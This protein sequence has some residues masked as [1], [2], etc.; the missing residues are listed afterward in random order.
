MG[1]IPN[2]EQPISSEHRR[3][4]HLTERVSKK[5]TTSYVVRSGYW[6]VGPRIAAPSELIMSRWHVALLVLS[7]HIRNIILVFSFNATA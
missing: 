7:D 2:S 4:R 1:D 5:T 6:A 3:H